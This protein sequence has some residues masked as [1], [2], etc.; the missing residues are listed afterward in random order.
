MLKKLS[1]M[2]FLVGLLAVISLSVIPQGA[3]PDMGLSDKLGHLAAYA[4][5]ALAGG[6]AYRGGRSLFM[7][8]AGLLLLGLGL[9]LVQAFLPGRSASGYDVLA[10]VIGTALGAA[11]A[12]SISNIRRPRILG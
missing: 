4:C 7:I 3:I 12:I 10:N 1:R 11:A 5:L 2:A 8:A 6:I 9:E